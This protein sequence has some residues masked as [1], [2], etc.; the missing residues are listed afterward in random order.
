MNNVKN[1][2]FCL[3]FFLIIPSLCWAQILAGIGKTDIT[4]PKGTPSA[5]YTNRFGQ[6]MKGA[7]DPLLAIALVIENG[8]KQIALCSVDHL[9]FTY[10]MVQAIIEEVHSYPELTD[11]DVYIASSH[12]HAGGGAFLNIPMLGEALAG[13]YDPQITAF[14]I[15]QTVDA[16]I[17]AKQKQVPAKAG[18]GYGNAPSLS[19]YRGFWPEGISPLSDVAVIK[20]TKKD[21]LPLAVLFNYPVHPTI[22]NSDNLFFSADFVGYARDHL[23]TL[24]GSDV[25]PLYF[26][27]AQGDI[28]PVILDEN[29]FTSCSLLGE[30]LAKFVEGIWNEIK[31][32]ENL[33]IVTL[34]EPY[35]FVPKANPFGLNLPIKSYKS[36]MN[37]IVFNGCHAFLTIPGELS[38]LYDKHLKEKGKKIG[39]SRVSILGLTN[40]AHGY[41]I[42]PECWRR[43]TFEARLSF[44]GENYGDEIAARAINL[45]YRLHDEL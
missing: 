6:G 12:T 30:S 8:T 5:G 3:I 15:K 37:A 2:T 21:D 14:Y 4:P 29:G 38:C 44:G 11:C 25:Q 27:G 34:K 28:N 9:G 18:I 20:V 22:L 39:F 33:D 36:E 16:I 10:E 17:Q 31:T 13:P 41:I 24:I 19:Y 23:Q 7:H 32:E 40:D 42:L 45:L 1:R 26:N 43:K 35:E